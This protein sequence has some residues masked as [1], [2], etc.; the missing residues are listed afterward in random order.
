MVR[1]AV[2][3][4]GGMGK[5]VS[6]CSLVVLKPNIV[7]LFASGTGVVTDV[8]VVRAV[9]KLVFEQRPTARVVIGEAAGGWVPDSGLSHHPSIPVGD[10]FE[11]A[12][13]RALLTDLV[14][15]GKKLDIVDLNLD[16]SDVVSVAP[17]Y[18]ARASY[19][20]PKTLGRA[21]AIIDLPVM[22]VHVTGL[23]ATLKNNIGILPGNVYGWWK[24]VG[25][26]YPS[27]T[28]LKHTRDLWDEEIVDVS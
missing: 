23:T 4:L 7:E 20:I 26:P 5:F 22:K 9:A 19:N 15:A 3:L 8:K 24:A 17:P 13:Y 12:S 14:F 25:F 21:N 27:N 18:Y 2:D 6:G 11:L 10:G 1:Y 28:G 16:A